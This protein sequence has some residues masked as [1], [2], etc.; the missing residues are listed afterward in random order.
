MDTRRVI[1]ERYQS[2]HYGKSMEV[3]SSDPKNIVLQNEA[4]NYQTLGR[5]TGVLSSDG[6]TITAQW[7]G[8]PAVW[9]FRRIP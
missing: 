9:S 3:I 4:A 5:F 8:R 1:T 6:N 7:N 2:Q